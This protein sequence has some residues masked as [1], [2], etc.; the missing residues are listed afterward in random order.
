MTVIKIEVAD[1]ASGSVD[2]ERESPVLRYRKAQDTLAAASEPL[3]VHAWNRPPL[4]LAF[5]VLEERNGTPRLRHH[6]NQEHRGATFVDEQ[7]RSLVKHYS[8]LSGGSHWRTASKVKQFNT[9]RLRTDDLVMTF[10]AEASGEHGLDLLDR[11]LARF[12][13]SFQPITTRFVGFRMLKWQGHD[14]N[15]ATENSRWSKFENP[16]ENEVDNLERPESLS[17]A[18]TPGMTPATGSG[19]RSA[20]GMR[21]S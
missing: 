14:E 5:H 16:V 10:E 18:A 19:A 12:G 15:T 8:D 9:T 20:T 4:E 11:R 3:W 6:G 2:S 17:L 7:A 21:P 13:L 1:L